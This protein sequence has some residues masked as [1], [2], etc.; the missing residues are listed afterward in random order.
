MSSLTPV[1]G[2]GGSNAGSV[3]S[4]TSPLST[5]PVTEQDFLQLLTAEL[6]NQDPLQP[7]Q[8]TQFI[9]ELAQFTQLAAIT[10]L[11]QQ[12]AVVDGA[13]LIGK[14]VTSAQGQGVVQ[15]ATIQNG[16]I[17]LEVQGVGTVPL[18]AVTQIG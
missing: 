10:S 17:T 1:S 5:P 15:T 13:A 11:Q 8:G 18:T 9:G 3:S 7:V 6:T 12:E 14:T 2:S 4:G 16:Q